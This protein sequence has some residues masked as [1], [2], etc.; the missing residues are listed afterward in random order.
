MCCYF[1]ASSNAKLHD[2]GGVIV[3][4]CRSCAGWIERVARAKRVSA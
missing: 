2:Y 1:C 4:L 3:R